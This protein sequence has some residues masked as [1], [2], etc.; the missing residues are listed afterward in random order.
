MTDW[1]RPASNFLI[2]NPRATLP[3]LL[4]CLQFRFF[5]R[6]RI[7]A[8]LAGVL[9][10]AVGATAVPAQP[11]DTATAIRPSPEH[12]RYWQYEGEPVLLIGGSKEDNLFQASDLE[13][14]LDRLVAAGGNY[15]RNTMSARDEGNAW[16]FHRG[17]DDTYDLNRPNEAYY[18]RLER[19]LRWAHERDVVV[20]IELWDRFDF[21]REPWLDNPFRPAN[22]VNYTADEIGLENRYPDHPGSNNNPFF[23]SV[24]AQNDNESLRRYQEARIERL[25]D[26]SLRYPNV[27]YVVDNE[28]SANPDWGAYW[29]RFVEEAA[30]SAG[31]PVQVTEMW[32][33]WNLRGEQHR[34]TLDHPERYDYAD[35]SQN[36]HQSDQQHWDNLMWVRRHTAGRP[37]V[38]N[39]VKIYGADAGR[40][41]TTRDGVERFWRSILGGSASARFHRPASGIGL[42][43]TAQSHLRSARALLKR[44]DLFAAQPDPTGARLADRS[45]DEAYLSHVPEAQ[46]AVYFPDGGTVRLRLGDDA[47]EATYRLA[48]LDL[49]A[50]TWATQRRVQGPGA[51]RLT[52]PGPGHW[53]ALLTEAG[54]AP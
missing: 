46:Y 54:A 1:K 28:T 8:L 2:G 20:Q 49:S 31:R 21:A 52:A 50:S 34:R 11:S 48:W 23:R 51:V 41:G 35:V 40:Y 47:G 6:L 15:V 17:P 18:R 42:N 38:L 43:E 26:V 37:W 14:H 44:F 24:P 39:N 5:H 45:P 12:P 27:L 33:D 36:N 22:N 16:A 32:D 25:L 4:D 7:V 53:I 29:A 10:A 9:L 30:D 13:A 3:G 19:L